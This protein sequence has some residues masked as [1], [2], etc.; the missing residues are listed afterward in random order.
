MTTDDDS[1]PPDLRQAVAWHREGAHDRAADAYRALLRD[2]PD[3]PTIWTNLGAAL[4][5]LGHLRAA[6]I[7]HARA[8]HHGPGNRTAIANLGNALREEGDFDG[9]RR[10][11]VIER[12]GLAGGPVGTLARDLQG[13]G[14]WRASLDA[15]DAAI[16]EAPDDAELYVLRATSRFMAGDFAGGLEDYG[17]RFRYSPRSEPVRDSRRWRGGP[18]TGRRLLVMAEQGLGDLVLVSRFLPLLRDRWEEVWVTARGPTRRLLSDV[19]YVDRVFR[20]EMPPA[21]GVEDA[22]VPAMDLMR[23]FGLTPETCPPPA[24]LHVPPDSR[25][26]AARLTEPYAGML[27]VGI[28]WAGSAGFAQARR[29]AADLRHF[30]DLADIPGVQLFGM[31]KGARQADIEALGAGALIVDTAST[32]RDLADAAALCEAM[33]VVVSVD[34]GLAHVAGALGVP[35]WTLLARPAFWYWGPHG[36]RSYWYPSMRLVRQTV[37]GNWSHPFATVRADLEAMVL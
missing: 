33:D 34:T 36:E 3:N 28:A 30:L 24:P 22:H 27:K 9:A 25:V 15:F 16:A 26:R 7:C 18:A 35:V 8:L 17:Q 4:R 5:S 23:I 32:D 21:E 13:M 2:M 29:K 11:A 1:A 19:P 6:K 20:K 12:A 37:P 14:H 31:V 10:M